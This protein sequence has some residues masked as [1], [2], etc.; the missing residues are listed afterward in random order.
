[1]YCLYHLEEYS[2]RTVDYDHWVSSPLVHLEPPSDGL[3]LID[4]RPVGVD[5]ELVEAHQR[6]LVT[7]CLK[8][9]K[10]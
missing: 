2:L 5:V 8:L 3:G 4:L 9:I 6:Q 10:W 7:D 1:M